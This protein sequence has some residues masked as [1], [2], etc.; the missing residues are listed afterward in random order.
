MPTHVS[1]KFL[2]SSDHEITTSQVASIFEELSLEVGRD[3]ARVIL[4]RLGLALVSTSLDCVS[5]G[6]RARPITST[7]LLSCK[8]LSSATL[9]KAM[10]RSKLCAHAHSSYEA[11][12]VGIEV[13][14]EMRLPAECTGVQKP[15]RVGAA[16]FTVASLVDAWLSSSYA[17]DSTQGQR[18]GGF[19]RRL[20]LPHIGGIPLDDLTTSNLQTVLAH[21]AI[22]QGKPATSR[23]CRMWM[24]A[25]LRYAKTQ[26]RISRE[27]LHE[28]M[29][30]EPARH[31]TK[32]KMPLT[33]EQIRHLWR[34]LDKLP[35]RTT[36]TGIR[37]LLLTF[38]RPVE[39][40]RA[41]WMEFDLDGS[42]NEHGPTWTIPPERVKMGTPHI[43]PLS[44]QSLALLGELRKTSGRQSLLFPGTVQGEPMTRQSWRDA[45]CSIGWEKRFSLHA[46]RATASTLMRELEI[47]TNDHIEIQ[48][49][50]LARSKT[51]ASYD[52]ALYVRQRHTMMQRWADYVLDIVDKQGYAPVHCATRRL[53]LNWNP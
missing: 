2:M 24:R 37:L 21:I 53:N 35:L 52:F 43:V 46:C 30:I 13:V 3:Q 16:E 17:A 51:R 9:H 22:T 26:R 12:N 50:H 27:T 28:F 25:A 19:L 6:N 34:D 49:G 41:S 20:V 47:G 15:Q 32:H 38:V 29:E 7:W 31:K 36:V 45:L 42:H 33:P 8:W 10:E 40:M 4:W 14:C 5:I 1:L 18:V 39:L 48:L 23:L 44:R 11:R